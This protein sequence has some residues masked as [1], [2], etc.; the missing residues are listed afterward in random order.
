MR[1]YAAFLRA[2][3]NVPQQPFRDALERLGA[4]EVSSSGATGNLIFDAPDEQ[5]PDG[6]APDLA[7]RVSEAVGAEAFIRTREE[8]S[9]VV[10]ENPYAGVDGSAV[11]L[12]G[13][14]IDQDRAQALLEAELEGPYPPV[15]VGSTV[16]F[17][18][19]TR[20]CGRKTIVDF[21]RELG[22]RG[23]MRGSAVVARVLDLM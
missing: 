8:L 18:H 5:A 6:P 21:E 15:I 12:A 14:P 19:P 16:Y 13:S 1:R 11:F 3:S 22:V 9:A 20:R 4:R 2:I 17:V 7:A 23:T 10:S